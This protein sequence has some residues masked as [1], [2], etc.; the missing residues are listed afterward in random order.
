MVRKERGRVQHV[1]FVNTILRHVGV[2]LLIF[3]SAAA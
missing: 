2:N 1:G 3:I